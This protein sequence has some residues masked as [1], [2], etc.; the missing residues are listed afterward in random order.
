[1]PP[2]AFF[3]KYRVLTIIL[4]IGAFA[5]SSAYTIWFTQ[6]K[7]ERLVF[8]SIGLEQPVDPTAA[9]LWIEANDYMTESIQG[10][11]IDPGFKNSIP[12]EFSLSVKKQEKQNLLVR[13]T[14][15]DAEIAQKAATAILENL[16]SAIDQYNT[17]TKGTVVI[18]R[19]TQSENVIMPS[20]KTNSAVSV[21]GTLIAL[22]IAGSL[23][24]WAKTLPNGHAR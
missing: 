10:W 9:E 24:Y 19:T 16:Q 5:I 2:F 7:Y 18:T 15:Q 14:A 13:A 3:W 20:V 21:I 8:L 22:W 12:Y 11:L 4:V 17:A 6:P 1:M 23:F